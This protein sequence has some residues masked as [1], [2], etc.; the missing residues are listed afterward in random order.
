VIVVDD[1]RQLC[2]LAGQVTWQIESCILPPNASMDD[3]GGDVRV[4]VEPGAS[5]YHAGEIATFIIS[6]TNTRTV[7]SQ[8]PQTIRPLIARTKSEDQINAYGRTR[9]HRKAFSSVSEA[10]MARPPTSPGIR[11]VTPPPVAKYTPLT[12]SSLSQPTV[13]R[14]GLIGAKKQTN[15]TVSSAAAT[16]GHPLS[17]TISPRNGE[18]SALA[19]NGN[20]TPTTP[21]HRGKLPFTPYSFCHYSHRLS[22]FSSKDPNNKRNSTIPSPCS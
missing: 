11:R 1:A 9:G 20:G 10:R 16:P 3:D 12:S 19:I 8:T 13:T 17:I 7:P 18:D 22:S 21:T 15:G 14:K 4:Y 5:H 6:F 2:V